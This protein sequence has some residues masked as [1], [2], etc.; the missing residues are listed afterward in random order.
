VSKI[1]KLLVIAGSAKTGTTSLANWLGQRD[2]M[3]LGTEKEC[4]YFAG[5]EASGWNGPATDGFM[6][7]MI[8]DAA[9]YDANFP[10]L[11]P[12][13]WAIDGSTDYIWAPGTD[14]RLAAFSAECVVKVIIIA[15]SPLSR[16]VSE[17]NHTLRQ[18][19]ETL[20]FA[21]S[22]AAENERR[23]SHWH[24]LFYHKRR[25]QISEDITRFH[26]RFGE[27]LLVL[28]YAELR[29]T[30]AVLAKVTSFLG[31][32][33]QAIDT[34]QTYNVSYLEKNK[35]ASRLKHSKA[36]VAIGRVLLP[37]RLKKWLWNYLHVDAK[38]VVTVSEDEKQA[39]L[40]LLSD[41]IAACRNNPLVPTKN[42]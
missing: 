17:Y 21:E 25:S 11:E 31:I 9:L 33:D 22:L 8:T 37:S 35:L 18:G 2:D 39:Y 24:P 14:A 5:F 42:W 23:T 1:K 27:N 7:T 30:D 38:K 12:D 29:D 36:V 40:A 16:A 32:A 13:Q 26:A 20:S 15:R 10:D 6:D 41:E 3:V 19:W 34:A 28:D 4:R